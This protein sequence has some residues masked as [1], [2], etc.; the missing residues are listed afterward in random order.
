MGVATGFTQFARTIGGTIGL[1][2]FGTILLSLYHLRIDPLIPP[3]TPRSLTQPFDN[4]LQLV[5]ARPSLE[6]AFSQIANGHVLLTNLLDGVRMGLLSG[7]RLI[8]LI[9]A[10]VMGVSFVLSLLQGHV[11]TQKES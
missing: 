8:F 9:S 5:L 3:N 10:G 7:L 4:P 6:V 1:A 2:F 11:A